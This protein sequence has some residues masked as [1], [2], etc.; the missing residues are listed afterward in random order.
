MESLRVFD[1]SELMAKEIAFQ[2]KGYTDQA[3]KEG[4]IFSIVL[5]GG[6]SGARLY[7]EFAK[8]SSIDKIPWHVVHLFWADERCVSPENEESNYGNCC[9]FLLNH[10]PIPMENVHRIRGEEDPEAESIRYALEIQEHAL[11]RKGQRNIFD[12]VFLGIGA[13]GHTASLFYGDDSISSSNMCEVVR[14]PETDQT[15]ITLTPSA[16]KKSKRT[17]YHVIGREKSGIISEL[18][19]QTGGHANYPAAHISGEWY[20]DSEAAS[21]LNPKNLGLKKL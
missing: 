7:G 14:H 10:I 15:R 13:D 18:V 1:S 20:L 6:S 21:K 8:R 4:N 11:L 19:S 3:E 16:I 12:W 2:L 9:H 17:T 5:S